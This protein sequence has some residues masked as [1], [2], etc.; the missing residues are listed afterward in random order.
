VTQPFVAIVMP[1]FQRTEYAIRTLRA[2][3]D[4]L[5]YDAKGIYIADAGSQED[6]IRDVLGALGDLHLLGWHTGIYS[7][8]QNWNLAWVKALDAADLVLWVEDDWELRQPLD[9]TPYV[10]LLLER[11][12]VGMVRLGYMAVGLDLFSVGHDGHHYLQMQRS[13][14]CG[15]AG[16]PHLK[17]RRFFEAYGV[18]TVGLNPGDTELDYDSKF[19]SKVGPEIWWPIEVGGWGA[20]A[21][22]G[23]KKTF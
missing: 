7:A 14:Q 21:H 19:R 8:G 11:Q 15:F 13:T 6:H 1:T 5:K 22:I 9:I 2:L 17:H 18:Y 23:I 3:R 20:F 12:D 10:R 16:H 4:N